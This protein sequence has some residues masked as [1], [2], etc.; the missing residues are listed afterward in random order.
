MRKLD[1][2]GQMSQLVLMMLVFIM[3]LFVFGNP[4]YRQ[5]IANGLNSVLYP[6]IGFEG[7]AP[8]VTMILAGMIMITLSSFFTTLFTDWKKMGESQEISKAFQ[9][10][11][12]D[13]RKKGNENRVKKLMKMQPEIMKKQTEASSGMMKPMVFL[14]LFIAPIFIWLTFFLGNLSYPFFT[15]PWAESV[16]FYDRSPVYISNWFLLYLVFSLVIGQ[17]I[18]QGLKI[19]S[20]TPRWKKMKSMLKPSMLSR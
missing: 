16:Y 1:N 8:V 7:N 19:A 15:T 4:V 12:Q 14:M 17:L 3:I 9:K 2:S 5:I 18:R 6:L 20:F 13:A 11:L 10:E